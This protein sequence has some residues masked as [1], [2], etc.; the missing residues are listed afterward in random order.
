[1]LN[2]NVFLDSTSPATTSSDY[3]PPRLEIIGDA[4]KVILGVAGNG[5]DFFGYTDAEFEF[6]PDGDEH[7][8]S[9]QTVTTLVGQ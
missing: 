7:N 4:S 8:A 5:N 9:Q 2:D 6:E 1:M 3:E